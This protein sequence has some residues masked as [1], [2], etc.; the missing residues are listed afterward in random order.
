M[1][2]DADAIRRLLGDDAATLES[3]QVFSEIESTNS[4]LMQQPGPSSGH[5]R[6]AATDNQTAGRGRH[7]RRWQS[8]PGSGLCLSLAYTFAERPENPSAITLAVGLGVIHALEKHRVT[9]V[10][11]KWPNDLIAGDSKLGGILTEAH[12]QAQADGALTVVT[13]IGLNFDLSEQK[14]LLGDETR[15]QRVIDLRAHAGLTPDKNRF[16]AS[17]VSN[18]SQLMLDYEARGFAPYRERWQQRDWLRGRHVAIDTPQQSI[19]GIG[20]GVAENGALMVETS[21][22]GIQHVTSGTVTMAERLVSTREQA[23]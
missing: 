1:R 17:L 13:G 23:L 16:A 2:L 18:L 14:G 12:G 11:L 9:D 20:V 10:Q 3:L 21:A 19:S 8:P 22:A 15:A 4:Y 6:V 7:G 5:F